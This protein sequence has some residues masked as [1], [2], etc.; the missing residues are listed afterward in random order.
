[1]PCH[2][3]E[4]GGTVNFGF[5]MGVFRIVVEGYLSFLFFFFFFM[6]YLLFLFLVLCVE[7]AAP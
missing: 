1:M 3:S 4:L 2:W 5:G 6:I 7:G